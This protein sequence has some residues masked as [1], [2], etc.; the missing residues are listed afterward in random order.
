MSMVKETTLKINAQKKKNKHL[1]IWAQ[2]K[3][4]KIQTGLRRGRTKTAPHATD[5]KRYRRKTTRHGHINITH[6]GHIKPTSGVA[7]RLLSEIERELF[8]Q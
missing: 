8:L 7:K 5:V 6:R 1:S 3:A 2:N 4:A